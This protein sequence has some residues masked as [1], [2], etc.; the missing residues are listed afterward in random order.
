MRQYL[1]NILLFL[2][3]FIMLAS[4][5]AVPDLSTTSAQDNTFLELRNAARK[6]DSVKAERLAASLSD[7]PVPSYVAYYRLKSRLE[8]ASE[9]EILETISRYRNTAI[10][11]R[12]R[13]DWLLI[14]GK[15]G[16][17]ATFDREYPLFQLKDDL[18]LKCYA[19]VS[20]AEK[21]E[22]VVAEARK[23]LDVSRKNNEGCY[24][25]V[26]TLKQKGQFKTDDLWFET[27]TAAEGSAFGLVKRLA[28]LAGAQPAAVSRALEMPA[29]VLSKGPGADRA[30]HEV[31]ILALGQLAKKDHQ[32][33]AEILTRAESKLT[34]SERKSAWAQIA[35]PSSLSLAPA[36]LS[37]WKKAEG[38][39]LSSLAQEWRVRMA[40]RSHDW[41]A[42][43]A[44]IDEM[45]AYLRDDATWVY[46]KGR[47]QQVAGNHEEARRY[48][49]SIADQYH[50]YGQLAL[51]ELGKK[52]SVPEMAKPITEAEIAA[53]SKNPG[54]KLALKF[55]SMNMRFEGVR[56]WN[57]QLRDMRDRELLAA[58]EFAKRSGV[59][60]RMVNTS[61]RTQEEISFVQRFP[62]PFK[63]NMETATKSLGLNMSW[64]YGLIRQESR[65]IMDARSSAGASGLMQL[66]PA[67]A[68]LVAKKIGMADYSPSQIN[69]LETNILLGTN[70]LKMMMEELGHSETL[71]TAGYNAGPGRPRAWRS[72]LTRAVEGA[73]FAETIPFN[74]TRDYVKKVMSNATYYAA[75][76]EGQPQ[77]LKKRMGK[78]SPP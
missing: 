63:D 57:W 34:A 76:V 17:W 25:L 35:L 77:S 16:Q 55:F 71:A 18:Q 21:G 20:Q 3:A 31:F 41:K 42:V 14:L 75:L 67:T 12:L 27:R 68:R 45:S 72:R 59:L 74:E 50:F 62:M 64:A 38:A 7:Y 15:R 46:W 52:I 9:A 5:H 78:V 53:M 66:M 51:E 1:K 65:F 4:A 70:Y 44:W 58:A 48:F 11:D 23:L 33:A 13:N 32:E 37:Y 19:L 47:A 26:S 61:D 73:I 6:Q 10:A 22:N 2:A 40:L 43:D 56:E 24:T 28:V 49:A 8:T 29:A 69:S 54:F 39:P 36:A 30:E 60:D